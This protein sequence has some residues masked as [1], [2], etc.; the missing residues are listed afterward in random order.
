VLVLVTGSVFLGE[1]EEDPFPLA[2]GG[3]PG[4]LASTD[5]SGITLEMK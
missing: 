5:L 1:G 2:V 3:A 4:S